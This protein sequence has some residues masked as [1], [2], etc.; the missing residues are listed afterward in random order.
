M[1]L[2][3]AIVA[4][5]AVI[6]LGIGLADAAPAASHT[7]TRKKLEDGKLSMRFAGGSLTAEK[8]TAGTA[9]IRL[10]EIDSAWKI[11]CKV[12]HPGPV[13][14]TEYLLT[15]TA[16]GSKKFTKTGLNLSAIISNGAFEFVVHPDPEGDYEYEL[17]FPGSKHA[18]IKSCTA[19]R[20]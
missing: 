4:A 19:T 2:R 13:L 16:L 1:R 6:G 17:D 15:T 20:I 18:K 8:L 7:V 3:Y 11:H 5:T 10:S 9:F 12:G 14:A